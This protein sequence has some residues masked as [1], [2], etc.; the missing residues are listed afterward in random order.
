MGVEQ[1]AFGQ[2][3]V[4][5]RVA[6]RSFDQLAELCPGHQQ[7]MHVHPVRV[8]RHVSSLNLLVVDGDQHQIDIGLRP[9]GVVRQAATEDGGQDGAV[10]LHLRDERVKCFTKPRLDRPVFHASTTTDVNDDY[11]I[12]TIQSERL[13]DDS[14]CSR[15]KALQRLPF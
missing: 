15:G 6:N 12:Q 9:D 10:F 13:L 11:A 7:R 2:E 1:P 5:E 4:H 3:R 8:E 14:Q